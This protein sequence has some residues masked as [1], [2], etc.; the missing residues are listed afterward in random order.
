M[1]ARYYDPASGRFASQYQDKQGN[2]WFG[3]ISSD[4]INR[5]DNSGR[6]DADDAA[7]VAKDM[8]GWLHINLP[9]WFIVTSDLIACIGKMLFCFSMSECAFNGATALFNASIACYSSPVLSSLMVGGTVVL[10]AVSLALAVVGVL[11]WN[12]AMLYLVALDPEGGPG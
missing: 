12:Q 3:C 9:T 10:G 4:P 7:G 2:N 8:A 11:E 6:S 1:R 5:S